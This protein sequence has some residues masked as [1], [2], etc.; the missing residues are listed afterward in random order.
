[1]SNWNVEYHGTNANVAKS[2]V[3]HKRIMFPGDTL[4][5][6]TILEVKHNQCYGN[7]FKSSVIYISP[8]YMPKNIHMEQHSKVKMLRLLSNVGLSQDTI[9][10]PNLA[11]ST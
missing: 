11:S 6:G 8:Q 1:M 5:D 10:N 2:I 4:N 7:E 9:F 3:E